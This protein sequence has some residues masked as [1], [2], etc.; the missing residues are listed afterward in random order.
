MAE[1]RVYTQEEQQR[2]VAD[3]QVGMPADRLLNHRTRGVGGERD[4]RDRSVKI[5]DNQPGRIP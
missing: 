4:T 5:A 2:M 1:D 3:Q